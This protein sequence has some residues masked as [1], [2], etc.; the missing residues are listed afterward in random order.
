MN[1]ALQFGQADPDSDY[2]LRPAVFGLVFH[3]EKIA[4]VRVTRDT[5]YYDLPGGAVDGDETETQA[6]IR[7]FVEET[8]MTVRPLHRIAEAGQFF[9]KSDGDPVNNVGGFWIAERLALDPARKIEA[10]HELVWL[11]PRT[12][13]AELRHDAHAWAVAKWLRR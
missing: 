6:L 9:R 7:E 5:P 8:G 2:R 11:H 1:P 13:L 12:A 10:D 3:D 4:C